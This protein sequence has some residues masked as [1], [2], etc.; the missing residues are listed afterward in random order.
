MPASV[1]IVGGGLSGLSA[2]YQLNK[3]DIPFLLLEA[4]DR[5]GG[6]ILSAPTGALDLGPSWFWPGQ[7][8]IASLIDEL[9]LKN[10]VYPQA[11]EGLS[12]MEYGDGSLQKSLGGA[13]M[14]GSN[15]LDGGMKRLIDTLANG[16]STDCLQTESLVQHISQTS[17]GVVAST[18]QA[19]VEHYMQ[20]RHCILAL[21]PR[22]VSQSINFEPGLPSKDRQLLSQIPTWMACQAKLV[23]E[24]TEPFWLVK[25]KSSIL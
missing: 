23:A 5:L 19:G 25:M 18:L 6:R 9:D 14:A 4:R 1:V 7:R 13:S 3:H 15:R 16:L 8:Q 17:D 21:P 12:V 22:V 24:Y 2:A 20:A 11:S 10:S